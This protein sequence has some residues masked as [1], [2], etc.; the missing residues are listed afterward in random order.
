MDLLSGLSSTQTKILSAPTK[1][2]SQLRAA[3]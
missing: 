2:S 1:N 3:A